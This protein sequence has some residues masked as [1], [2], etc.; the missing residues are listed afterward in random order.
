MLPRVAVI[1][2]HYNNSPHTQECLKSLNNITADS[3]NLKIYLIN[4]GGKSIGAGRLLQQVYKNIEIITQAGNLGYAKANNVGIKKALK[5]G[6]EYI[7]LLN[8]DTLLSKDFLTSL[9]SY[10][11]TNSKTGCISPKIYFAKGYE[12]HKKRYP[13]SQLGKIIW[14]AGGRIDWQ[15]MNAFHI[16]V[17]QYDQKQFDRITY[18]DFATGCC[19]VIRAQVIK[20]V[21]YLNED[22]FLYWED[23][24]F[25][26]RAKQAGW[27]IKYYPGSYIWHKNAGAS[28]VGS[29]LHNYYMSRNRL[30]FGMQYAPLKT[31][32]ALLKQSVFQLMKADRWIRRGIIDFY[33]CHMRKG[34]Y[35]Q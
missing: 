21:G 14:Y 7:V 11:Q 30:W 16:G 20:Q 35:N 9:I 22:L 24:D 34:S 28:A 1:I 25:S 29:N 8:N 12:Y 31:K 3:L 26:F 13:V 17:D 4:Y 6:A 10:M 32:L 5:S 2:L 18:T 33:L 19:L 15:N 27:D 23:S